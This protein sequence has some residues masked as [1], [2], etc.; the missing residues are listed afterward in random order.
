MAE[1]PTM[2]ETLVQ[3]ETWQGES[4]SED[5]SS[6]VFVHVCPRPLKRIELD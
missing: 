1:S 3:D 5:G 2:S 6:E 4:K